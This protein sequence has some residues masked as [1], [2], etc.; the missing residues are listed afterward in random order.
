MVHL[1]VV[2]SL[3]P[4]LYKSVAAWTVKVRFYFNF[5]NRFSVASNKENYVGPE[6]ILKN[7]KR[8]ILRR[9]HR[10]KFRSH[11]YAFQID[12]APF[13]PQ[14]GQYTFHVRDRTEIQEDGEGQFSKITV[15]DTICY[16][17]TVY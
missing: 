12:F 6:V 2:F 8:R 16:Y 17:S 11:V 15:R 14:K 10:G 7:V 5:I 13:S 3:L 9:F 1:S 4:Y